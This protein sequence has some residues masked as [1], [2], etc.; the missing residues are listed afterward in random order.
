M[1]TRHWAQV[2]WIDTP[3]M[4]TDATLAVAFV[5]TDVIEHSPSRNRTDEKLIDEAVC[6]QMPEHPIAS[7]VNS[8]RPGPA[9][10]ILTYLKQLRHLGELHGHRTGSHADIT[11]RLRWARP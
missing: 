8:P 2:A 7:D 11:R 3:S 6:P 1:G 10:V 9:V 5:M 4:V